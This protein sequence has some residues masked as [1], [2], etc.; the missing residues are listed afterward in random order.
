[1]DSTTKPNSFPLQGYLIFQV[2]LADYPRNNISWIVSPRNKVVPRALRNTDKLSLKLDLWHPWVLFF[3]IS[4][5]HRSFL[6]LIKEV[7]SIKFNQHLLKSTL[8]QVLCWTLKIQNEWEKRNP[9]HVKLNIIRESL[10]K[11]TFSTPFTQSFMNT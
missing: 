1:M 2:W 9:V 4:D 8:W 7:N 6:D 3:K 10:K 5:I 11:G